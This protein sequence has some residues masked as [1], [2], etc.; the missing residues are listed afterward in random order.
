MTDLDW[1]KSLKHLASEYAREK[2]RWGERAILAKKC[3]VT[4]GYVTN[5]LCGKEESSK[6]FAA[7]L[8]EA[9]LNMGIYLTRNDILYPK[10]SPNPIIRSEFEKAKKRKLA[11]RYR[12]SVTRLTRILDGREEIDQKLAEDMA[13]KARKIGISLTA[14]DLLCP[15]KSSHPF[16]KA[17]V[18]KRRDKNHSVKEKSNKNYSL[19]SKIAKYLGISV[20]RTA[21]ILNGS[22][23]E[24]TNIEL[25]G[26][27]FAEI[28]AAAARRFRCALVKEDILLPLESNNPVIKHEIERS[29][30]RKSRYS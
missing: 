11:E 4:P 15:V 14:K 2:L 10:E 24:T 26:E 13:E 16:L 8:A 20:F 23:D 7:K 22:S 19:K 30:K 17:E 18:R 25:L 9:A 21:K 3:G 6:T 5:I 27:D 1:S 28:V 29:E 12:I